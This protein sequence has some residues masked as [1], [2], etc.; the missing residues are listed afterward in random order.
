[1][2]G[3]FEFGAV[4]QGNVIEVFGG[5][6]ACALPQQESG[7]TDSIRSKYPRGRKGDGIISVDIASEE[8]WLRSLFPGQG[9]GV[10]VDAI[11]PIFGRDVASAIEQSELRSW[12]KRNGLVEWTNCVMLTYTVKLRIVFGSRVVNTLHSHEVPLPF[13]NNY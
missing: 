9:V 12:E 3:S 13:I 2:V 8:S 5:A 7:L 4:T 1:M 6:V 10:R 11:E